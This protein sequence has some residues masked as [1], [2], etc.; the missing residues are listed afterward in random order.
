[1]TG[2]L[3][4]LPEPLGRV[5]AEL[6][7]VGGLGEREQVL[8]AVWLT[9]LRSARTRRAYARDV[10]AWPGWLAARDTGVLAAGR[11]AC[12]LHAGRTRLLGSPQTARA[13]KGRRPYGCRKPASPGQMLCGSRSARPRVQASGRAAPSPSGGG[14]IFGLWA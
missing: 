5:R 10:A 1:M 7:A 13:L 4:L 9:G 8:V 6:P 14:M 3:E 11:A 2:D 12:P